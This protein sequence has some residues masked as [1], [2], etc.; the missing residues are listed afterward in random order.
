MSPGLT[1]NGSFP[2]H[3]H[4]VAV[5]QQISCDLEGESVVL[6]LRDGVYYGLNEVAAKVWSLVQ[7]PRTI[8]EIR[9]ALLQDY[10]VSPESCTEDLLHLLRQMTEWKLVEL[11]NGKPDQG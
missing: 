10:D 11:R 5:E 6:N 9:D 1:S 7:E 4:V 8:E 2:L 3:A